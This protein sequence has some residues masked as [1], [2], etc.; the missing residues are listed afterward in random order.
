MI[1]GELQRA[2]RSGYSIQ[3][4]CVQNIRI[5]KLG[6][7]DPGSD[8]QVVQGRGRT[9]AEALAI[10]Q[11][12]YLRLLSG[13]PGPRSPD[14]F[15]GWPDATSE[16]EKHLMAGYSLILRPS[17]HDAGFECARFSNRFDAISRPQATLDAA[18]HDAF[19]DPI[20][21]KY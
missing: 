16:A 10:L 21:M 13:A 17:A 18:I 1:F 15:G 20:V 6:P 7:K 12:N 5:A 2:L 14:F 8:L 19:T 3:L 11:E 4:T 9:L